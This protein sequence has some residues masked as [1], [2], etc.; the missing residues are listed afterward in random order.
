MNV[1]DFI[2]VGNQFKHKGNDVDVFEIVRIQNDLAIVVCDGL[3]KEWPLPITNVENYIKNG[4][5][6]QI[7]KIKCDGIICSSCG[8]ENIFALANQSDGSFICYKCRSGY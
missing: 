2:K 5:W 6:L 8:D 4:T 1:K 3:D 7:I